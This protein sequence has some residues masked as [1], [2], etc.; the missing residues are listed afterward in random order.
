MTDVGDFVDAV[1]LVD[2]VDRVARLAGTGPARVVASS[3]TA[4]AAGRPVVMLRLDTGAEF[5]WSRPAVGVTARDLDAD[6]RAW[7]RSR[8]LAG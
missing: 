4:T 6:F 8:P 1:D 5:R 2:L 7:C 3:V